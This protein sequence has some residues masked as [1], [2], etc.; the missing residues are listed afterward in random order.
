MV[1]PSLKSD[2]YFYKKI[3]GTIKNISNET[4]SYVFINFIVYDSSGNQLGTISDSIENFQSGNTWKFE[5]IGFID[6]QKV[7]SF[8]FLDITYY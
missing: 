1:E 8:E 2:E 5:A 7:S 6:M 4:Y 3:A